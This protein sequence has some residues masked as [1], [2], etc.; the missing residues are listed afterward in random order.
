MIE[1][2]VDTFEVE[3]FAVTMGG[4]KRR[5]RKT[6]KSFD[7]GGFDFRIQGGGSWTPDPILCDAYK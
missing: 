7:W 2:E 4:R 1:P 3:S 6:R 5:P